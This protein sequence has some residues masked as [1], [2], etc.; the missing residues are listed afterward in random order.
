MNGMYYNKILFLGDIKNCRSFL[1][2]KFITEYQVLYTYQN[3]ISIVDLDFLRRVYK[4]NPSLFTLLK[5]EI[6]IRGGRFFGNHGEQLFYQLPQQTRMLKS[7]SFGNKKYESIIFPIALKQFFSEAHVDSDS[8]FDGICIDAI[9]YVFGNNIEEL[10]D[11]EKVFQYAGFSI[12]T[13]DNKNYLEN[14]NIETDVSSDSNDNLDTFLSENKFT[15]IKKSLRGMNVFQIKN[16]TEDVIIKL[17]TLKGIGPKR[18]DDLR[19]KLS[20]FSSFIM[21][22]QQE[23]EIAHV[24]FPYILFGQHEYLKIIF[25]DQKAEKDGIIW[26]NNNKQF[27]SLLKDKN[28][29]G[30]KQKEFLQMISDGYKE[31]IDWF[32]REQ[33]HETNITRGELINLIKAFQLEEY[34]DAVID[35]K[36]EF[37]KNA[38][39]GNEEIINEL[40]Y[41][42]VMTDKIKT[43]CQRAF[44]YYLNNNDRVNEVYK[45]DNENNKEYRTLESIGQ[46]VG[47][48]RERVRQLKQEIKNQKIEIGNRYRLREYICF[49]NFVG[50]VLIL[51]QDM[52][53]EDYQYL[54]DID[55]PSIIGKLPVLLPPLNDEQPIRKTLIKLDEKLTSID[56]ISVKEI[57]TIFEPF[58]NE[59]E[60]KLLLNKI[61]LT[62]DF[63]YEN[64]LFLYKQISIEQAIIKCINKQPD[65][66]LQVNTESINYLNTYIQ[67]TFHKKI[68]RD[69]LT[70]E[71]RAFNSRLNRLC[72]KG[73]IVY[74]GNYTYAI[75]NH[76]KIDQQL[77][78]KMT[79]WINNRLID[80]EEIRPEVVYKK[81]E[82]EL[83]KAGIRNKFEL[84]SELVFLLPDEFSFGYVNTQSIRLPNT[85]KATIEQRIIN[86]VQKHGKIVS[87]EKISSDIGIPLSSVNHEVSNSKL[88]GMRNKKISLIEIKISKEVRQLFDNEIERQ[89][90]LHEGYVFPHEIKDNMEKSSFFN[91]L[92]ATKGIAV[93]FSELDYFADLLTYLWPNLKGFTQVKYVKSRPTNEKIIDDWAG[94]RTFTRIE[95]TNFL[96]SVGYLNQSIYAKINQLLGN[97]DMTEVDMDVFILTK[98]I[99]NW[100]QSRQVI[101]GTNQYIENIWSTKSID[102]EFISL[103]MIMLNTNNLPSLPERSFKLSWTK[104]LLKNEI[105][106]SNKYRLL[107]WD[108]DNGSLETPNDPL[109]IV[110]YESEIIDIVDLTRAMMKKYQGGGSVKDVLAYLN[111]IGILQNAQAT[112]IPQVLNTLFIVNEFGAVQMKKNY[113]D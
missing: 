59:E 65:S 54:Y 2:N 63:Q 72:D 110:P 87:A 77:L 79:Q 93:Y 104:E 12:I 98:Y 22:E 8:Y 17:T 31:Y 46:K 103:V 68:L 108:V 44:Q 58:L 113:D 81:F 33:H 55:S 21:I 15:F 78:T 62:Y 73:E 91:D 66:T 20:E 64:S 74:L 99:I 24:V 18:I 19:T 6:T 9:P 53:S 45:I 94:E 42:E 112:S 35:S 40:I 57:R 90:E 23:Q 28:I 52:S 86:Y 5:I 92:L 102:S 95:L 14:N 89:F 13:Y 27:V 41:L 70:D 43:K 109:I 3:H 48:T 37:N 101:D 106:Y 10:F 49:T 11:A 80:I 7:G 47:V 111:K 50:R 100:Q 26:P 34:R 56:V 83:I 107:E 30:R 85:E 16:I 4:V 51:Q 29:K 76:D 97:N 39:N 60:L 1:I 69:N 82:D 75:S 25:S 84:Y 88:L 36:I 67:H 105:R 71:V 61:R 96:N 32:K 38:N